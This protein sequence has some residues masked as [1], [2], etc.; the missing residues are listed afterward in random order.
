MCRGR[1]STPR[2]QNA[3]Q[4]EEDRGPGPDRGGGIASNGLWGLTLEHPSKNSG[5]WQ[6][7]GGSQADAGKGQGADPPKTACKNGLRAAERCRNDAS[8]TP[9][10]SAGRHPDPSNSSSSL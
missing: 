9:A 6:V 1:G 5:L 10:L 3:V 7:Q 8:T 2:I 4:G